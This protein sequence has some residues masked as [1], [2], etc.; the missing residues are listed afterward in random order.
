M[1]EAERYRELARQ[2]E[3]RMDAEPD[4]LARQKIR[5]ERQAWLE[6]AAN[7]EAVERASFVE[8]R[9]LDQDMTPAS[10]RAFEALAP[11]KPP[12]GGA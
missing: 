12:K 11:G 6:L 7:R 10:L 8:D 2:C 9:P 1:H 5:S 3:L 4:L